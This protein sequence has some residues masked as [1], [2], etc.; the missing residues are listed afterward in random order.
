LGIGR[1]C[2]DLVELEERVVGYRARVCLGMAEPVGCVVG[3]RARVCAWVWWSLGCVQLR[4]GGILGLF[5]AVARSL[6]PRRGA[7]AQ[8][9]NAA[10]LGLSAVTLAH[11]TPLLSLALVSSASALGGA[12]HAP[13]APKLT[14]SHVAQPPPGGGGGG[15]AQ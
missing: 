13:S 10:N 3:Y 6:E 12:T 11:M 9:T 4:G 14:L 1:V 5:K 2:L 7:N 15:R 8:K